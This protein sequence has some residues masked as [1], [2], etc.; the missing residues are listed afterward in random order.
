MTSADPG[1]R[2]WNQDKRDPIRWAA[3][4]DAI[5]Q[6]W[7]AVRELLAARSAPPSRSVYL[8]LP[9]LIAILHAENPRGEVRRS[10]VVGALR[11]LE[12]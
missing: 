5:R 1:R 7:S 3:S 6:A 2:Y 8:D 12:F 9:R 11:F 4:R 10:A